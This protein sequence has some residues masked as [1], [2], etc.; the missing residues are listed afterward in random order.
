MF[1]F[2]MTLCVT[3]AGSAISRSFDMRLG[4]GE[5]YSHSLIRNKTG[6]HLTFRQ[7]FRREEIKRNHGVLITV[8]SLIRAHAE[9]YSYWKHANQKHQLSSENV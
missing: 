2:V 1:V 3:L 6:K 8:L 4:E 5:I 9:M 7:V